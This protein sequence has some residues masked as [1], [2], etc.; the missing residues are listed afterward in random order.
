MLKNRMIVPPGVIG[1]TAVSEAVSAGSSP[2]E[3]A[4][5]PTRGSLHSTLCSKLQK[6]DMDKET[7]DNLEESDPPEPY[8]LGE[9]C[10]FTTNGSRENIHRHCTISIGEERVLQG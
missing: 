1:S 10:T 7:N 3:A 6:K 8:G 2:A 4:F 5:E 9:R